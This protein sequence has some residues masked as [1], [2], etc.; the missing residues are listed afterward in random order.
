VEVAL[1]KWYLG[2][3]TR[4]GLWDFAVQETHSRAPQPERAEI[5]ALLG[6]GKRPSCEFAATEIRSLAPPARSRRREAPA[7]GDPPN[8]T[9]TAAEE[10]R[11]RRLSPDWPASA[12]VPRHGTTPDPNGL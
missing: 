5:I 10:C 12:R 7:G 2:G 9:A 1:P 11:L 8:R 4:F 3:H 6:A